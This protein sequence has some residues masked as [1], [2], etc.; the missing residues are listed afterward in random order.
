[1]FWS[2][3]WA[4]ALRLLAT[5]LR[6]FFPFRHTEKLS[7]WLD[8]IP[9]A[10]TGLVMLSLGWLLDRPP[11]EIALAAVSLVALLSAWA[12]FTLTR[13]PSIELG[14]PER[15]DDEMIDESPAVLWRIPVTNSGYAETARNVEVTLNSCDVS[16][17]KLLPVTL[18]KMHD[19]P[20]GGTAYQRLWNLRPKERV[21]FDLLGFSDEQYYLY[22]SDGDSTRQQGPEWMLSTNESDALT[23]RQFTEEVGVRLTVRVIADPPIKGVERDYILEG[24]ATLLRSDG[25]ARAV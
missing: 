3:L 2:R 12:V 17:V 22:R 19:N 7:G 15:Y 20:P 13:V 4:T 1:M 11:I 10:G 21:L 9:Y 25:L 14:D 5:A 18:H 16:E 8:V 6:I 23:R 24:G